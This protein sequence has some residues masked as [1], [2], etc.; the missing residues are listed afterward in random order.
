MSLFPVVTPPAKFPERA[1]DAAATSNV[2]LYWRDSGSSR[3]STLSALF[4]GMSNLTDLL[5]VASFVCPDNQQC[6]QET[7][8][9]PAIAYCEDDDA[10]TRCFNPGKGPSGGCDIDQLCWYNSMRSR[11]GAN[12]VDQITV[13][14]VT[15]VRVMRLTRERS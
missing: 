2:C 13:P 10:V 15:H 4:C 11:V 8:V 7:T 12:R 9:T 3:T 1:A 5:S 6:I 14:A